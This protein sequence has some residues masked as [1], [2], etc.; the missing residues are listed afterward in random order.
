MSK[1]DKLIERLKSKPKNFTFNEMEALL[2]SLG[3]T[4]SNKG[5]TSGS[6]VSFARGIIIIEIHKPHPG[7]ELKSYQIN[8]V[9][10]RLEG[11][12]LI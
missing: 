2:S 1:S 7:N 9:L 3:F 12:G 10:K 11:E 6:R 8:Q 4:I 5:K